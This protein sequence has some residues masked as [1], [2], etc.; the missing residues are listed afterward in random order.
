MGL[1]NYYRQYTL[2]GFIR[3]VLDVLRTRIIYP[4]AKIIRF[5]ID[6]RG[7]K[8]I[9]LGRRLTTGRNCR[10]EAYPSDNRSVVL[11][12]GNDVQINDYVHITA[13]CGVTIGDNVLMASK[14]Y[15]S[16]C[17]HGSY[18]GDNFDSSPDQNPID[19]DYR[20]APVKIGSNVWI[21]ESASILPGV[22]IGTGSIVGA[23][24]VVTKSVP[25]HCLVAGVPARVL[26]RYNFDT[27]KWERINS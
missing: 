27:K 14:I 15:I 17:A 18:K 12:F 20:T 7:K 25:E 11:K 2:Y 16:D 22:E 21:G 19:R 24:S 4:G 13:M 10:L 9:D 6:I 23:N 8:F 3:L 1:I 26:K 5:P